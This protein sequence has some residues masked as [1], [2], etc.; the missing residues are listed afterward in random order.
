MPLP[1]HQRATGEPP[2][3][4][5][6][7]AS[8]GPAASFTT[9]RTAARPAVL[10]GEARGP[11]TWDRDVPSHRNIPGLTL[12]PLEAHMVGVAQEIGGPTAV[13]LSPIC[14]V[15]QRRWLAVVARAV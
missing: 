1:P 13:E 12:A 6:Q 7:R 8:R 15:A 11:Y 3:R 14:A 9:E 4:L 5:A 10:A 2:E